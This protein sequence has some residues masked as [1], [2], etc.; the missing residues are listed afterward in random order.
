[1]QIIWILTQ[2]M[3]I[4]HRE[5]SMFFFCNSNV[6]IAYILHL[7]AGAFVK[8]TTWKLSFEY[9]SRVFPI[10]KLNP[11]MYSLNNW[12]SLFHLK[13]TPL[14]FFLEKYLVIW[15]SLT[16]LSQ[17][18]RGRTTRLGI[19]KSMGSSRESEPQ[20]ESMSPFR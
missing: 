17:M 1:M 3:V 5:E 11:D 4:L 9:T 13:Q 14:A 15:A 12:S 7:K 19:P 2:L 6:N 16:E 20:L 8:D 10:I 18:I